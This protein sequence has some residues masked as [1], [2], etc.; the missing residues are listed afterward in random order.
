VRAYLCVCVCVYAC[1][2]VC[3]CVFVC[4]CAYLCVCVCVCSC[5]YVCVFVCVCMCLCVSIW[6]CLWMCLHEQA[7]Q[8]RVCL[9]KI[10]GA[11]HRR[12]ACYRKR[13]NAKDNMQVFLRIQT[14]H[15]TFKNMP[16]ETYS[17]RDMYFA[18]VHVWGGARRNTEAQTKTIH[19]DIVG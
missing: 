19:L 9:G 2:S 8:T 15:G 1:V 11:I 17:K 5:V 3:I 13:K 16:Q 7:G 4:V 14:N 12:R 10:E 6:I 18:C